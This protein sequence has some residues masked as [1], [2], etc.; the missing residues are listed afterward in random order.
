MQGKWEPSE[1][2]SGPADGH[3]LGTLG[4]IKGGLQVPVFCELTVHLKIW[5]GLSAVCKPACIYLAHRGAQ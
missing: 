3:G 2:P 4:G 1:V 5:M